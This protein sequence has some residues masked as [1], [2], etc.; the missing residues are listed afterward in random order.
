M[1]FTSNIY[2]TTPQQSSNQEIAQNTK[3]LCVAKPKGKIGRIFPTCKPRTPTKAN[4]RSKIDLTLGLM[5]QKNNSCSVFEK[6]VIWL[7]QKSKIF[8]V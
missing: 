4:R 2:N 6:F 7:I 8:G 1:R 5:S 3:E